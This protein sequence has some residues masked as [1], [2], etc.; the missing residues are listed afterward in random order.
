MNNWVFRG[1]VVIALAACSKGGGTALT[2][3]SVKDYRDHID[4]SLSYEDAVK[5]A[6]AKFGKPTS[7]D[8]KVTSWVGKDGDHCFKFSLENYSGKAANGVEDTDC[9][10]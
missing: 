8:A 1:I 3:D 7:A 4:M 9:P 5:D 10:K 2:K 6:T